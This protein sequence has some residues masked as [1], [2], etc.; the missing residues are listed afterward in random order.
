[1]LIASLSLAEQVVLILAALILLSSFLMLAQVR[2]DSMI[3][4]FALQG[5]LLF[6]AT[7][8]MAFISGKYDLLISAALTLFLK[9]FFICCISPIQLLLFY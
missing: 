3:N 1:M 5:L 2:L 6:F 7:L 9:V 8:L 4:T